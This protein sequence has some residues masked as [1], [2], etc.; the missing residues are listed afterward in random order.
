MACGPHH[1][2]YTMQARYVEPM[3]LTCGPST[4]ALFPWSE[5][6]GT[7]VSPVKIIKIE[8]NNPS[9][10]TPDGSHFQL[11]NKSRKKLKYPGS[12]QLVKVRISN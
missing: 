12:H 3:P 2:K 7:V 1:L 9:S 5:S 8:N 10:H 4:H 6:A 11:E